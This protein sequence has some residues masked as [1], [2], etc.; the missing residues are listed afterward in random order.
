MLA[1]G[2]RDAWYDGEFGSALV[3]LAAGHFT[4]DDLRA[5]HADWVEPI[6]VRAWGH[7][8]W[9]VPPNS[10]GYL[11]LA[12]TWMAD[13]VGLPLAPEEPRWAHLLIETVKQAGHDRVDVLH[14][15]ADGA[16]LL[17]PQRLTARL[18][19]IDVS[20]AAA[21]ILPA[22]P[23]GTTHLNVV[24]DGMAVSLTQSNCAG[25]GAHLVVP[26]VRVYL[27]NRGIGFS[28]VPDHPAEYGPRRRPPHT[29]CPTLVTTIDGRV[30]FALGTMGADNQPMTLLQL[31]ARL[32]HSGE[33]PAHAVTAARWVLAAPSDEPFAVWSDPGNLRVRVEAHAP[34]S[35][36]AELER[37][38]HTVE[39]I[40]AYSTATG[41]AQ[42]VEIE[43][44]LR[45][46]GT[47]AM[48]LVGS[49]DGW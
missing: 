15:H 24:A 7:D 48:G 9:T 38:G 33:D 47:I 21:L 23:G 49:A 19:G 4:V 31:L 40:D 11:T 29:L 25:F 32:L 3:K 18:D 39:V 22:A 46:N 36:A 1:A 17:D 5:S 43:D 2:G 8:V 34:G 13:H 28:V 26:G 12:G 44:D 45:G 16:A 35:W 20:R 10:Q 27:Q 14:E 41:L 30:R 42:I 37:L 6:V